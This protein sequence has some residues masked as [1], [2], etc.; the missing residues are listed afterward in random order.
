MKK[1]NN[2]CIF[3]HIKCPCITRTISILIFHQKLVRNAENKATNNN[4]H[5][6]SRLSSLEEMK[7]QR[8]VLKGINNYLKNILGMKTLSHVIHL[9]FI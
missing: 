1:E 3:H 4:V 7:L 6:Q 5:H 2:K 8:F 9:S